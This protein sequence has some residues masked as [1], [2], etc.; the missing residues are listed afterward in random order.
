[1]VVGAAFSSHVEEDR[2]HLGPF[3]LIW[4]YLNS[5]SLI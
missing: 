4:A 3:K 2:T 5:F 1:M